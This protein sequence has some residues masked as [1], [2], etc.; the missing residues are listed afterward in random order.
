MTLAADDWRSRGRLGLIPT[1]GALHEGHLALVREA[2]DRSDHVVVSIF[3]NPTQFG[4]SED[5]DSYPRTLEAD[6]DTLERIGGVDAVFL[7]S[8]E[9]FYA[10]GPDKQRTWITIDGMDDVLCGAHRPGH[11]KGVLTVVA[12]L[13]LVCK[14]HVACFG[15]KD[16][17]Q[18]VLIQ[19][20]VRDL[21]FDVDI[22]GVPTVREPDGL[23]LSS[24]NRYLNPQERAEA[25]LLSRAV[26]E[27]RRAVVS[28]E[29]SAASVTSR[30][31]RILEEGA[32]GRIQYAECVD[33]ETLEPLI[34]I[35]PGQRVLSA[36]A[37]FLG[38]TRLIDNSFSRSPFQA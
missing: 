18:F 30:M 33:A 29:R 36:V 23:A 8:T 9:R 7:P 1:M 26:N 16:A 3:V 37:V 22:V 25:V 2:K 27:A 28:G 14:P 11:F 24:R 5:F 32:L 31:L 12:K 13:L 17:Q 34:T 35:A 21:N 4:P 38:S 19:R 20:M 15:L 10:D 6:L